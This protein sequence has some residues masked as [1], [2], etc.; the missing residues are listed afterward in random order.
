MEKKAPLRNEKPNLFSEKAYFLI[1][2][3][4]LNSDIL[5]KDTLTE[6]KLAAI[7]GM[8]RTPIREALIKLETE[9]IITSYGK[10]GYFIN[11]P[12]MKE[13]KDMY[14]IRMLLEGGAARLA[15]KKIDFEKLE[16]F[17]KGF[18]FAKNE[19]CYKKKV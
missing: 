10:K 2:E 19:L 8:S 1:R 9:G 6:L 12:T 13:I 11:L 7:L 4:I 5:P 16:Y 3:M 17:K 14:E 15:A 18:I